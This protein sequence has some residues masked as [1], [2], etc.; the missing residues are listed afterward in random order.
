VILRFDLPGA[1]PASVEV[2]VDRGVLSVSATREEE[3]GVGRQVAEMLQV[4][5]AFLLRRLDQHDV[6]PS[7]SAGGRRR[8]SRQDV[9]AVRHD[10]RM[11]TRA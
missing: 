8:Y 9:L 6:S 7:R 1:D 5:Q 2:T 4:R 10:T 3:I 11:A